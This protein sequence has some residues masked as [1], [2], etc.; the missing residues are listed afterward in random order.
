[1]H[2]EIASTI[3][4]DPLIYWV[5]YVSIA[6]T[7]YFRYRLIDDTPTCLK[8]VVEPKA[9]GTVSEEDRNRKFYTC[10]IACYGHVNT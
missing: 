6:L 4:P 5:G 2:G 10:F 7:L 3:F 9:L 8:L 1:M